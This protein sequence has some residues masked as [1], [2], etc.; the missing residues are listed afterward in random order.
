VTR[1][2]RETVAVAAIQPQLARVDPVAGGT[3]CS[4]DSRPA[5]GGERMHAAVTPFPQDQHHKIFRDTCS[6]ARENCGIRGRINACENFT[7]GIVVV[8][9]ISAR[10]RRAVGL[11]RPAPQPAHL[12]G[13]R[14]INSNPGFNRSCHNLPSARGAAL[15]AC[16][17]LPGALS[18]RTIPADQTTA[19]L[20]KRAMIAPIAVTEV[21]SRPTRWASAHQDALK[22]TRAQSNTRTTKKKTNAARYRFGKDHPI[23]ACQPFRL[24]ILPDRRPPLRP[25]LPARRRRITGRLAATV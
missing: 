22:R 15:D 20:L 19:S 14:K 3:V 23:V 18:P 13:N 5:Y 11:T 2:L 25:V 9:P 1:L 8:R 21:S 12:F 4:A 24:A 7:S 6:S 16:F 17:C 10:G